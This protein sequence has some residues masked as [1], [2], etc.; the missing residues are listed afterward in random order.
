[1]QHPSANPFTFLASSEADT[2][3]LGAA[4]A[5]AV[6]PGTVIA[7]QGTLGSGKT[8]LVKAIAT[9]LEIP[10]EEVHSPTFVIVRQYSGQKTL[11]HFDVYRVRDDDEFLEIGPEEYFDSSGITLLEWADKIAACLPLSYLRIEIEVVGET[12][13]QFTV[14]AIGDKYVGLPGEIQRLIG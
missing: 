1:M 14:S 12:A 4:L 6:P 9:A 13:R 11:N 7:L 5:A 3:R 2:D 8:R 10:A